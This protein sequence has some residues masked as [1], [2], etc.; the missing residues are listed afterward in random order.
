MTDGRR[1]ANGATEPHWDGST[2]HAILIPDWAG[3]LNFRD[4]LAETLDPA[5]YPVEYL[6][7]L[8]ITGRATLW[9]EG[10]AIMLTE[11]RQYPGGAKVIHGLIA[12]GDLATLI[13][14]LIPMAENWAR[15]QGCGWAEIESREGWARTMKT[16]G[17][18]PHQITLRKAL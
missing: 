17:Y 14:N 15:D 8:V 11:L 3:Y 2:A 7:H 10:D 9:I 18:E 4:R 12:S 13:E 16:R 6:D 1:W 5:F